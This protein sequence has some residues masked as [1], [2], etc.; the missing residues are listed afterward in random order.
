[1]SFFDILTDSTNNNKS[2]TSP[3][4]KPTNDNSTRHTYHS[5]CPQKYKIAIIKK[6]NL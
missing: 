4:K 3:Y 5:E 2:S 6:L 1:M